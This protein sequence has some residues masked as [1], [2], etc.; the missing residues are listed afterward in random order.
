MSSIEMKKSGIEWIGMIHEHWEVKRV[1]E[2]F[3]SPKTITNPG[4]IDVLSL[5]LNGV[6]EKD[7]EN[8]KGLNPESYDTYQ[9]FR[10]NDLVF[11]LIDLANYQTSRVGRVWKDGIMSSAYI[12]LT[13]KKILIFTIFSTNFLIFIKD[14]YLICL[15]GI[16]FVLQ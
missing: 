6:I 1:S 13:K 10:K 7:I 9:I 11:K 2:F 16:E 4:R 14:Q 8:N 12:R 15:V 3:N 5:T